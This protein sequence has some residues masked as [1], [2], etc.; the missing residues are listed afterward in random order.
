MAP[1]EPDFD[2]KTFRDAFLAALQGM[3]QRSGIMFAD[4]SH[5]EAIASNVAGVALAAEKKLRAYRP[6]GKVSGSKIPM[7]TGGTL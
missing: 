7:D 2:Y 1:R 6:S 4:E 5:F 3:L